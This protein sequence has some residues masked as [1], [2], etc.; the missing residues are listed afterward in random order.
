MLGIMGREILEIQ[1]RESG[2]LRRHAT[3]LRPL[4]PAIAVA[5]SK[6]SKN[7]TERRGVFGFFRTQ[8]AV[9]DQ[10]F[11][12]VGRDFCRREAHGVAP[13]PA[14]LAVPFPGRYGRGFAA[15]LIH[16]NRPG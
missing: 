13:P 5:V 14:H 16:Y 10:T 11:N 12:N 2:A 4:E 3:G 15:G 9:P 7:G 6:I 1:K 8:P